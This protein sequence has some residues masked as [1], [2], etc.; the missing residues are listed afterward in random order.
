[1]YIYQVLCIMGGVGVMGKEGGLT[2][3]MR[4]GSLGGSYVFLASD[5]FNVKGGV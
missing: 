3:V 1:M 2:S 4:Y 5:V